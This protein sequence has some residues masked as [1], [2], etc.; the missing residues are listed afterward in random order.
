MISSEN[1]LNFVRLAG[2]FYAM[3]TA[4][5]GFKMKRQWFNW[6]ILNWSERD[7]SIRGQSKTEEVDGLQG[8][9]LIAEQEE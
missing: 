8:K 3:M 2:A 1:W 6:E 7:K 4:T 5:Y 9:R